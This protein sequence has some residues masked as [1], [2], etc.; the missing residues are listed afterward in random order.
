VQL[1]GPILQSRVTAPAMQKI[2]NATSSL[3]R[4][5]SKNVFFYFEKIALASYNAGVVVV[6]SNVVGSAHRWQNDQTGRKFVVVAQ[7]IRIILH[8]IVVA[9]LFYSCCWWHWRK[10]QQIEI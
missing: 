1:Q 9:F 2:S 7:Q 5:E 6:N 3:A 8:M 4:F 10:D